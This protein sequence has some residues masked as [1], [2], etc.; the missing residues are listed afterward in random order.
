MNKTSYKSVFFVET[1]GRLEWST[2]PILVNVDGKKERVE[3]G[4]YCL[5]AFRSGDGPL[6]FCPKPGAEFEPQELRD[7]ASFM[8]Q[9]EKY[10]GVVARLA[11]PE[12][13]LHR[14]AT[15]LL[16]LYSA[17]PERMRQDPNIS[18]LGCLVYF[19][20][21]ATED[22]MGNCGGLD[23][24]RRLAQQLQAKELEVEQCLRDLDEA[25][26]INIPTHP[27]LEEQIFLADQ[28]RRCLTD[29]GKLRA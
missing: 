24:T 25:G 23:I 15:K 29:H 21:A 19:A 11:K 3:A 7:I 17:L 26:Y 20:I 1:G 2:N 16:N 18:D 28:Q 5:G 12:D 10:R 27:R 9:V 13:E 14:P 6:H 8:E 4:H 22:V